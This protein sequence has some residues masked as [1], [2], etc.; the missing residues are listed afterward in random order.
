MSN[1]TGTILRAFGTILCLVI[2]WYFV[3]SIIYFVITLVLGFEFDLKV[4]LA[5]FAL[6]TMFRMF[7]PKNVFI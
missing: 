3:V 4:S 1:A 7:Y 5:L 6:F 2:F